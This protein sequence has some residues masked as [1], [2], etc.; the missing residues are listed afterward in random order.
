MKVTHETSDLV[1]LIHKADDLAGIKCPPHPLHRQSPALR[2]RGT[3]CRSA[4]SAPG[5]YLGSRKPPPFRVPPAPP[6][7]SRSGIAPV[8]SRPLSQTRSGPPPPLP[9]R[10]QIGR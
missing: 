6:D 7:A 8:R 4:M 1:R 10:H 3:F 9:A 5:Q 2:L